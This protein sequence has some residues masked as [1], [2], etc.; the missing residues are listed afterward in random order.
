MR[1]G[2]R[3]FAGAFTPHV[4]TDTTAILPVD[5]DTCEFNVV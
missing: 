5:A 3:R 1:I 4:I 2:N